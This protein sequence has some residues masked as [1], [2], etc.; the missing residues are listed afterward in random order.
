M[1]D[2]NKRFVKEGMVLYPEAR[3]T[4]DAFEK[5]IG[6]LLR[7]A[8]QAKKGWDPLTTHKIGS[9]SAG[10]G[11]YGSWVAAQ[12]T[13][14]SPRHR[15]VEIDCGFWWNSPEIEKPIVYASFDEKPKKRIFPWQ[16]ENEG[17][18]SFNRWRRTY[19]YVRVPESVEIEQPLNRV[20][21]ALLKQLA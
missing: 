10:G 15:E 18:S 11:S 7:S 17:I 6:K 20:L 1:N 16:N 2:E 14:R 19:L 9:P 13:G 21:D 12:I 3:L 8:L 4:L 5:E